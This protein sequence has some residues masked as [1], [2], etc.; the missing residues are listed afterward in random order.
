MADDPPS[1]T[2]SRLSGVLTGIRFA[3]G[4]VGKMG[5]VAAMA[6]G[7]L[8]FIGYSMTSDGMKLTVGFTVAGCLFAYICAALWYA[9]KNPYNALLE[10]ADLIQ[11]KQL[12]IAE[13]GQA[14][15]IATANVAPP[16]VLKV[17]G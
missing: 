8:G 16:V 17:E 5:F 15:V 13:R 7:A 4:V 11:L 12:E 3:P 1:P 14:P 9:A 6:V 2:L 10:G